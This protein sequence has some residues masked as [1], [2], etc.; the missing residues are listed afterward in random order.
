[1]L[2][3]PQRLLDLSNYVYI[4]AAVLAVIA[5]F[6][7]VYFGNRVASLKDAELKAYQRDAD[8]RIAEAHTQSATADAQAAQANAEVAKANQTAAQAQSDAS[9][10]NQRAEEAKATAEQSR[11]DKV[12]IEKDNLILQQQVEQEKIA[13]LNIE[14]QLANRSLTREQQ[15]AILTAM[16]PLGGQRMDLFLYPNDGEIAAIA[17]QIAQCL[18]GWTFKVF[19]PM[20]GFVQGMAIDYDPADQTA[21][22]R[23]RSLTTA[24]R[25]AGLKITE[26]SPSLPTPQGKMPAYTSD[27][28]ASPTASIRLTIGRK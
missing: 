3:D 21:L 22:K 19:F 8:A 2:T 12:K 9:I 23:A 14:K 27:G 20:G 10:A 15:M 24:L 4:T 6:S 7:I 5:T 25:Q 26:P 13:R 16:T 17:N 18:N 11:L 28:T 1:M